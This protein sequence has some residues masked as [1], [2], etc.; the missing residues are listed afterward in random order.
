VSKI[1][2]DNYRFLQEHIR[3]QSGI[4]LDDGKDYLVEARLLPVALDHGLKGLDDLCTRLRLLSDISLQRK[5]VEAM[6]TNETFF[7]REPAHFE[8]L[9]TQVLPALIEARRKEKKLSLWSAAA[10]T[11]QEAYSLAMLLCEMG[12]GLWDVRIV[13]TDIA[14]T[15][16]DRACAGV[17]NQVEIERGLPLALRSKYCA[18]REDDSWEIDPRLRRMTTFRHFDLRYNVRALGR[19]DIVFCRNVLIYFDPL[20]KSRIVEDIHSALHPG[21]YLFLGGSEVSLPVGPG[22]TRVV[23]GDATFFQSRS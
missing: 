16:V 7:F 6:T 22:F 8:A 23:S 19:F 12:L 20:T 11:G 1:H 10:S 17:Y 14:A 5:V 15:V 2:P 3:R 18:K 21:G 9:R 13:G 4:V